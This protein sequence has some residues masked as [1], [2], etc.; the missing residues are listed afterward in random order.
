MKK[1]IKF[2]TFVQMFFLIFT[3]L[4][5][6]ILDNFISTIATLS[7]TFLI[8]SYICGWVCPFGTLQESIIKIRKKFVKKT[9]NIPEGIDKKLSLLRYLP[10]FFAIVFISDTLDAKRIMGGLL[11]GEQL[12]KI[13]LFILTFFLILSF[14]IDR[15]FCRWFCADGGG[16]GILSLGRILTI[17][18]DTKI[19]INCRKCDKYCP[20]NIRVSRCSDIINPR[21]INCLS[22]ISSC[23]KQNVLNIGIRDFSAKYSRITFLF[24]II[25]VI[26]VIVKFLN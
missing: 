12:T 1:I 18:R 23:P 2:R 15:P 7:I 3:I 9:Y 20:M 6:K 21:C 17:K 4:S 5:I 19:C 26:W 24:A 22:C 13:S 16:Y 25:F 8:G 14:F 11:S 10:L